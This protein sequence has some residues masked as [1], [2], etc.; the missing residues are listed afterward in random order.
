MASGSPRPSVANAAKRAADQLLYAL[1]GNR[2]LTYR[3][4]RTWDA[5]ADSEPLVATAAFD[6]ADWETYW[7][8]GRRDLDLMLGVARQ[9]ATLGSSLA[10]EI[11]CGLGRLARLAAEDFEKVIATDIS[12][13]MLKQASEKASMPNVTYV[14]LASDLKLPVPDVTAD[15]VYAWTVFRH[16]AEVVFAGYLDESRRVLK[17]GGCLV[18]EALVRKDGIP[19]KPS[20]SNPVS[21][22]EYTRAELETYCRS[23]G[24]RWRADHE[25]PSVTPGT[26]NLVIAWSKPDAA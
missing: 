23:H 22:R 1:L 7:A 21:E 19:F 3:A 14:L 26:A 13:H 5:R 4:R 17:P 9:G 25:I 8:S 18:F 11:G 24:F 15:L 6:A 20:V 2:W 10:V 12:P 16:T